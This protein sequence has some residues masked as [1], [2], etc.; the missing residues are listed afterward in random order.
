M[1]KSSDLKSVRFPEG[2]IEGF[3]TLID[4]VSVHMREERFS[5]GTLSELD[6]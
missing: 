3:V 6:Q 4:E 1:Q 2:E 5:G